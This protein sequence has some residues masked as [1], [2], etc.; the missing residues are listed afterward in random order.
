MS[1]AAPEVADGAPALRG[2]PW[3][4][5]GW[6]RWVLA[7]M[8]AILGL[9][10][11][12][13]AVLESP[14]GHRFVVDRIARYA[15]AS[16]LRVEIGRFEGSLLGGAI[17]RDVRFSDP[18]GLFMQVP[19]VELDWRP[20]RWFTSGLDVRKLILR[21]GTLYRAPRLNPGDPEAPVLPDFDIR[22]D[23]FELDRLTVAKGMLGEERRIALV[24]KTDI[25][26]GRVYLTTNASLGGGDRLSGLLDSEPTRDRFA[27]KLDYNAPRGGLLAAMAGAKD[28]LSI[29]VNGA[30]RYQDWRGR[31]LVDQPGGNIAD[32][33]L[34]NRAGRYRVTGQVHP[35]DFV[36]GIAERVT[37]RTV[38]IEG[39]G[40]LAKS[41][42]SGRLTAVGEGADVAL[43]GAID[44]AGNAVR[45]L[46]IEARS[47][48]PALLGEGMR[49]ENAVFTGTLDGP[50][51]QLSIPHR[52]TVGR[53]A[54]GS[55]RL[56]GVVQE[57]TLTRA[58]N[59][60]TFPLGLTATRVVTGNAMLDPRL[61]RGKATGT[62]RLDGTRVSS[63]TLVIGVPGLGAALVLAG[64]TAKGDYRLAG[65]VAARGLDLAN[66]GLADAD[67]KLTLGFGNRP[68]LAAAEVRGRMTRVTNPTLT[69]LAGTGIR[70]AGHVETGG[71]QPLLLQR[72]TINGSKLALRL[73]GRNLPNG[74]TTLAGSGRHT[75]YGPFT[76]QAAI[77]QDGPRA[78]LV[79]ADPLPAAGLKNV[80][81]ALSPIAKGFRIETDGQSMLGAFNGTL[82]LFSPPGGPT[83]IVVE[84]LEVWK[85]A[86]TGSLV[87]AGGGVDGTLLLAGGGIDGTI[88]LSPRGG[89]QGF[90]VALM[91]DNARFGGATPLAI[92]SARIDVSGTLVNGHST[93]TGSVL[94]SGVQSGSLFIGR[95][96]AN[97]SL[98]DGAGRV[99]ASLAGRR[100]SRFNL[101]VL[102]DFVP[103]RVAVLANGDFAGQRITMPRRA[104]L[105]RTA[106]GWALAPAQLDYAGGR[107]IAEGVFGADSAGTVNVA[108]MPLALIDVFTTD[109]GL[110]GKAS[111]SIS[112]RAPRGRLPTADAR[113]EVKGLTRSG[114]VLTSRPVDLSLVLRL[115]ERSLETRAVVREGSA[116][117]GRIQG[118]IEGMA[119]AGSITERIM[120]GRLFAQ[121]RYSGPADAL[122]RLAALE[123]FDLTGPIDVAADVTG[124]LSDPAMRGSLASTALRLQ[125]SLTGTDVRQVAV[126]GAF[127]G[128]RLR[129]I[130]F[131]GVARNGGR[132][133]GSGTV[134]LAGLGAG[135]GPGIDIRMAARG[136]ELISRDD[137]AATV[138]GPLRIVSDGMGGTIAG[139]LAIDRA[140][141]N[142]GRASAA[143]SLPDV[144]TREINLPADIAPLRAR[145]AP[146]RYLVDA[147]GG[148]RI[149]VRG[150]GMDSEWGAD[151]RIR[152]TTDLPAITGRA[153]LVRGGYDFAG[154][155]FELTRGLITFDGDAPPDPRLDI[156]A[157][158]E[159]TGL[160]ASVAVTGTAS[161]PNIRFSSIPSL[162]EE[163]LLSRLLFGSSIAQISV[164]E[165]VQIGAALAALRGGGG[166]D[167]INKLRTA[168]GLDRLRII[169]ADAAAGRGTSVAVG[170]NIGRRFYA[171]IVTDGRGYN[172][173]M[174]EY[175]ITRWISILASVSSVGR[176]GVDVK[177]SKDY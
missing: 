1:D 152:G 7:A 156:A 10:G 162:P 140:R 98:R 50:F 29:R 161:R 77:A 174:L 112:W 131:A 142:L 164:P 3:I 83:R 23:R 57:A 40:S 80:R 35:A 123:T 127:A 99:T 92:G 113:I 30:G 16:G 147:R 48:N 36:S 128:S 65:P 20:L 104:V 86:V 38:T 37:G 135:R 39:E 157:T 46:K 87:L 136:A 76:L 70:F 85:T 71:Q 100:G 143:A 9:V 59:R 32:L 171:E 125:S 129:L 26:D 158:A 137:M 139:R 11:I 19:V 67:L 159:V 151:L 148:N 115:A 111:G 22:I 93:I 25:R 155:R 79:F 163:E 24:A 73:D 51:R 69:T 121:V 27:L 75:E 56:E 54:S 134:D 88:R 169:G 101:Q 110:G 89:G 66:I 133:S 63:D 5:S 172:A 90:D 44:L 78:T 106:T 117:R 109:L 8:L 55:V 114:L 31:A 130:S 42:L 34:G 18:R 41:V 146:W 150:L 43:D 167:P 177:L 124:S 95:L 72:F 175:R 94:A 176:E 17:L 91:A 138:T 144:K 116:I 15:P 6:R 84:R 12:G 13:V 120:G 28:G 62:I 58:D 64:D 14:I 82:A 81:V 149:D 107:L 154:K 105:T 21:R 45:A 52:I 153:Q 170:K 102:A 103:N 97:A 74:T 132:V 53:F 168:I 141:W 122:W 61:T 33:A 173:T 108:D 126:R 165:A 4:V 119:A 2:R 60:W 160:T 166:M 49:L 47:R 68:W 96:A 118:R 145:A